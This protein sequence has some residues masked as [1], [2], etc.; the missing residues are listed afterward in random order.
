MNEI[1]EKIRQAL[2]AEDRALMDEIEEEQTFFDL[3]GNSFRGKMKTFM[4]IA[5]IAMFAMF[6]LAVYSLVTFLAASE[7]STKINWGVS[8]IVSMQFLAGM[9]IWYFLELSKLAAARD[10]RRLELRIIEKAG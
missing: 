10:I 9:K 3:I 1:D 8:F 7:I 6:G 4:V 2:S 5:W